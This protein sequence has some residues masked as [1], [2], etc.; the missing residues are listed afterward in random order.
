VADRDVRG[1]FVYCQSVKAP[2]SVTMSV[3]GR[4]KLCR[5]IRCLGNAAVNTPTLAYGKQVTVGRFRCRSLRSGV[6][7]TVIRS[8]KGF[9]IDSKTVRRVGP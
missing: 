5:G 8:G 1:S 7:C 6:R 3:D 9:L 2:H 4:L